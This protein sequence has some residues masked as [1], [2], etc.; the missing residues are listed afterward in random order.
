MRVLQIRLKFVK[1][2]LESESIN[3]LYS[4]FTNKCIPTLNQ[5]YTRLTLSQPLSLRMLLSLA[6]WTLIWS[7]NMLIK[8]WNQVSMI[9][10][11]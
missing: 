4:L 11:R 5:L 1:F 6:R 8:G 3:N 7:L 2:Y 10:E 9:M